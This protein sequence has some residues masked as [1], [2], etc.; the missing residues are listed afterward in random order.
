VPPLPSDQDAALFDLLRS[1][2][3]SGG[4]VSWAEIDQVYGR[5]SP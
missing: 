4:H 5:K 3:R 1:S 2:A